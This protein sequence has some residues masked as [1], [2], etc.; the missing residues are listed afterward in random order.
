MIL[1]SGQ[2]EKTSYKVQPKESEPA[3]ITPAKSP[4]SDALTMEECDD[5]G[6]LIVAAVADLS[7]MEDMLSIDSGIAE[8]STGNEGG[9]E[10]GVVLDGIIPAICGKSDDNVNDSSK[11]LPVP[12]TGCRDDPSQEDDD[13]MRTEVAKLAKENTETNTT[14]TKSITLLNASSLPPVWSLTD[15]I[16][17]LMAAASVPDVIWRM[18]SPY[19]TIPEIEKNILVIPVLWSLFSPNLV[20]SP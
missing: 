1:D 4:T 11:S 15:R 17:Q 13:D 10:S 20:Y 5:N 18:T 3:F 8:S 14:V 19:R 6:L 2:D 12:A 16:N 7:P 9:G